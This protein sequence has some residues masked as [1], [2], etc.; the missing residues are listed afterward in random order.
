MG[1]AW[2]PKLIQ[3]ARTGKPGNKARDYTAAISFKVNYPK[4]KPYPHCGKQFSM[5]TTCFINCGQCKASTALVLTLATNDQLH[6]SL[7]RLNLFK[8]EIC[9]VQSQTRNTRKEDERQLKSSYQT[10]FPVTIFV[11]LLLTLSHS[12]SSAFVTPC[13]CFLFLAHNDCSG[14]IKVHLDSACICSV[15]STMCM[16]CMYACVSKLPTLIKVWWICTY[17]PYFFNQTPQLPLH[18]LFVLW[19]LLFEGGVYFIGTRIIS[20]S[21]CAPRV[22]AMTTIRRQWLNKV[23]VGDTT[24]PDRRW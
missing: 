10:N 23:H 8:P 15:H 20:I 5:V 22:L 3:R 13:Y 14:S 16:S 11:S 24:R 4:K 17:I 21:I 1:E 9:M 12:L 6:D 18:S 19:Q 2:E 7:S